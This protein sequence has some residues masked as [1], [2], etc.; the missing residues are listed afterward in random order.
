[1]PGIPGRQIKP[2]ILGLSALLR[3]TVPEM[4]VV[5]EELEKEG[6]RDLVKVVVGG[7]PLNEEYAKRIRA[8]YYAQDAW[9]G[10]TTIKRM[11]GAK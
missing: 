9:L 8:D 3:A 10:I 6:L 5:I 7:L 2:D 4:R 11:V 1:M